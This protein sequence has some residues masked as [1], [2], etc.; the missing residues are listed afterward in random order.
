MLFQ[1]ID[2][3]LVDLCLKLVVAAVAVRINLLEALQV[4]L[5]LVFELFCEDAE[6]AE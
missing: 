4:N 2:C 5:F 6:Q 1:Q 3:S